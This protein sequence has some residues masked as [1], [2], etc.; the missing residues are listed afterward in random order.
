MSFA[1]LFEALP[2]CPEQD[3]RPL[4]QTS[5]QLNQPGTFQTAALCQGPMQVPSLPLGHSASYRG[6]RCFRDGGGTC[7]GGGS[8]DYLERL[9]TS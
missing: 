2:L 5:N 4:T 6:E 9:D 1:E 3:P 8:G 7:F